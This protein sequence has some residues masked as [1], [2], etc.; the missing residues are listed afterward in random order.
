MPPERIKYLSDED[1]ERYGLVG[2]DP[3]YDE[4][5]TARKAA[6]YGTTSAD[7]RRRDALSEQLCWPG[8]HWPPPTGTTRE[9][10]RDASHCKAAML[11]GLSK[12]EY[13]RRREI[14]DRVC[15]KHRVSGDLQPLLACL[16]AVMV[17]GK[18]TY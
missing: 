10:L 6:R 13:L 8:G 17:D 9:E 15:E 18:S 7:Y 11:Y 4:Q 12:S 14:S 3:V 5:Q 16:L 1:A 2:T